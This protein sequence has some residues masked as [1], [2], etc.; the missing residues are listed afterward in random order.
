MLHRILDTNEKSVVLTTDDAFELRL[1]A[2]RF[3][4]SLVWDEDY[5]S[6][7]MLVSERDRDRWLEIIDKIN[8]QLK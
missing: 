1:L 6:D 4:E 3:R 5:F 8:A 2:D 7:A